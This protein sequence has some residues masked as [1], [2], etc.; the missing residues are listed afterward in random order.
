M[1]K[2]MLWLSLLFF[3]C[4]NSTSSGSDN[5]IHFVGATINYD[6]TA[7]SNFQRKP[8]ASLANDTLWI[9]DYWAMSEQP[10]VQALA[11]VKGDSII[12][13]Y[14]RQFGP[15]NDWRPTVEAI[16]RFSRIYILWRKS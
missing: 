3:A 12:V 1:Y 13:N 9:A 8:S 15:V 11:E 16:V 7:F 10:P 14:A 4:Q 5:D 2:H 6:V